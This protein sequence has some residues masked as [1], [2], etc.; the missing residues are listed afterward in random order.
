MDIDVLT[1]AVLSYARSHGAGGAPLAVPAAGLHVMV[2]NGPTTLRHGIYN[3]VFCLV[4]QGAKQTKVGGR[5]LTFG[6]LESL[7]VSLDL[8]NISR[9]VEASAARPYVALA[10]TL[11]MAV[12][13]ELVADMR[14]DASGHAGEAA[15]TTAA[16]AEV[17][18]AMRRLFALTD[19]PQAADV[20]RPLIVREVH[21]WLLASE[22][23]AMLRCLVQADSHAARIARAI[24]IIRKDFSSSLRIADLANAAGMSVSAFHEHF[25]AIT[26]TTPLQF[27]KQLKLDEARRLI[28][29]RTMPVASVAYEVGYESATQFSR[30]YA[31]H[32]GTPPL[33]DAR[34]TDSDA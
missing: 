33:R 17:V 19:R 25:R 9:I 27:Q 32:F 28:R 24:S 31:R 3:P 14:V 8:P 5:T 11:D 13:H 34:L 22:H 12:V 26:G 7:I 10:L 2:S 30:E 21:Y 16:C 29:M 23:G 18:D 15:V 1:N 4:L 20:L 6:R